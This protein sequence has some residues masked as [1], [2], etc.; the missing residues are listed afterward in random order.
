MVA[1]GSTESK[2]TPAIISTRA[3]ARRLR[4]FV[5][6]QNWACRRGFVCPETRA[7][8]RGVTFN[9]SVTI[10]IKLPTG[11]QLPNRTMS[12]GGRVTGC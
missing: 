12:Q 3:K 2:D 11:M 8:R 9:F 6:P 4:G 1:S 5:S 10:R 7:G